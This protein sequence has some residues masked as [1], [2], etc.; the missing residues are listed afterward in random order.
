[1]SSNIADLIGGWSVLSI[2]KI[3]KQVWFLSPI[4]KK[5]LFCWFCWSV[6]FTM[7]NN[8]ICSVKRSLFKLY[9]GGI[10]NPSTK[11]GYLILNQKLFLEK[12]NLAVIKYI[13]IH[14]R[15]LYFDKIWRQKCIL[16]TKQKIQEKAGICCMWIYVKQDDFK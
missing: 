9:T 15:I 5:S 13:Y 14:F 10:Y 1:M 11:I 6:T 8:K 12:F 7:I 2:H 16:P 4:F 3:E